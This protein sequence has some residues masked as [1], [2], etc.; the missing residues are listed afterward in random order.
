M[1]WNVSK[2]FNSKDPFL[3]SGFISIEN[4]IFQDH[5]LLNPHQ[6]HT[7]PNSNLHLHSFHPPPPPLPALT[8]LPLHQF[9][10][11]HLHSL[12]CR[13]FPKSESHSLVSSSTVGS[14]PHVKIC[15][16]NSSLLM[17]RFSLLPQHHHQ[18]LKVILFIKKLSLREPNPLI[19]IQSMPMSF[20]STFRKTTSFYTRDLHSPCPFLLPF[21]NKT[22]SVKSHI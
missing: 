10:A 4:S 9:Q 22:K 1:I 12:L 13:A 8:F 15:A 17:Q 21:F 5:L 2:P 7:N 16:Q 6:L 20:H 18:L 19:R 14:L 11:A 3:S